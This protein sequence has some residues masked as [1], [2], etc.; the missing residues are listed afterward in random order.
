MKCLINV[1]L[2]RLLTILAAV[3]FLLLSPRAQAQTITVGGVVCDKD[4]AVIPGVSVFDK[5]NP[6]N[7]TTSGLDG[8]YTIT[9]LPGARL[10]FS[11]MGFR[12]QLVEVA[13]RVGI[14][15]IMEED[16]FLLEEMVVI[17]YGTIRKSDLTGSVARVGSDVLSDKPVTSFGQALQGRAAGVYI[18]DNGNPQ[19][20]VSIKIRGLGTINDSNPLYVIDGAPMSMGLNSINMLDIESID[21][22]KDASA[23][24]I[25]GS[26]GANGV[27]LI[28]TKKGKQG[29]G[30]SL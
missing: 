10:E 30:F 29:E 27:V 28:T 18:V 21:I 16:S 11:Y 13:G 12:T 17:G 1:P 23:T 26:R 2:K 20:N 3:L 25:Y 15:I 14:D 9:V 4:H 22:L 8:T 19:E 24:A 7:L 6:D 5:D